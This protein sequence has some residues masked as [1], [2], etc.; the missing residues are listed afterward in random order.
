[1]KGN[2]EGD[3]FTPSFSVGDNKISAT[4]GDVVN[5]AKEYFGSDPK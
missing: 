2:Y 1:M 4:K 5:G 3:E